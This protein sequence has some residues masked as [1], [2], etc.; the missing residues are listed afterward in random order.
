MDRPGLVSA[1]PFDLSGRVAL[2]TGASR[3]IGRAIAEGLADAGA[4]L[5]LSSRDAAELERVAD[6]ARELGRRAAVVPTDMTAVADARALVDAALDRLGAIDVLVNVAGTT[7]RKPGVEVTED[8][9]D[10]VLNVNLKS[11]FFLTQA[12]GAYWIETGRFADGS[13]RGKGKVVSIT[14]LTSLIGIRGT[15]AYAVSKSGLMGALRVLALEWAPHNICVNGIAPGY[16]ETTLT[17]PLFEDPT[18]SA[19]IHSRIPSGKHG[20]PGDVVGTAVFLSAPASDYV[21]GQ[22]L[23]VDA[24]W[25]AS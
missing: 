16:I 14:S 25:M 5:V 18:F 22:N 4:D 2:V 11:T 21:S 15:L 17:R 9:W 7:R 3:G 20:Q 12:V 13:G 1:S 10:T 23:V 24:G 6:R 8:D 19:W